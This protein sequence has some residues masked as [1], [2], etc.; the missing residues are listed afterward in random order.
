LS[1]LSETL[2]TL[3]AAG[4]TRA[5]LDGAGGLLEVEFLLESPAAPEEKPNAH[6]AALKRSARALQGAP[7]ES[8]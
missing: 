7:E 1:T 2:D 3:K 5:K 8:S 4:V 6:A